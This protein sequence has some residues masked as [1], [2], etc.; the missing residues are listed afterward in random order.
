MKFPNWPLSRWAVA[1]QLVIGAFL[2]FAPFGFDHPSS[3][4]LD[5][6]DLI[7]VGVLFLASSL[8]ALVLA[9]RARDG[10]AT[11]ISL[12]AI[13]ATAILRVPHDGLD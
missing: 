13:P 10:V 12:F 11:A 7:R 8:V 6:D 9:I 2:A 3:W 5:F 4:G 1:I